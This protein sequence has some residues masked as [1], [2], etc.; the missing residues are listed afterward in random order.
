V[1]LV[2]QLVELLADLGV[3]AAQQILGARIGLFGLLLFGLEVEDRSV[4]RREQIGE[5]H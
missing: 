2:V 3:L 4:R 5:A 1:D